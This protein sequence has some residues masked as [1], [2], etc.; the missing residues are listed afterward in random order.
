MDW[1]IMPKVKK[2]SDEKRQRQDKDRKREERAAQ[3]TG[4]LLTA[5]PSGESHVSIGTAMSE[6]NRAK[7]SSDRTSGMSNSGELMSRDSSVVNS[8]HGNTSSA[9]EIVDKYLES[10]KDLARRFKKKYP[11]PK[12]DTND[13]VKKAANE[14]YDRT[15]DQVK[16]KR[17]QYNT[18]W[19]RRARTQS[20]FR[21]YEKQHNR[22]SKKMAR[23]DQAFRDDERERDSKCRRMARKDAAYR[24]SER[25]S[26]RNRMHV[27]RKDLAYRDNECESQRN[28][29]QMARKDPGYRVSERE[30]NRNS[31]QVARTN[32]A[33]RDNERESN[34]KSMQVARKEKSKQLSL[35]DLIKNFHQ[36]VAKGP[37]H[38]CCVCEQLWY[39]H[40][41]TILKSKSLPDCH[42]VDMCVSDLQ[43]SEGNKL[44][45]NTCL[46]HLKKKKIPPSATA[47]GMG[48]PEIPQHLKDLHQLEWR[49]VSP[50]IP[51]MK[52]F[53]APR[54]G[55][56]KIRGNVVNVPCDTVNTFQVLPHSGNEQQTIQVKIKRD[57][58]YTN[59]VMSQNV[60]PYKVREA[61]EYLVTHGKLFK[62]QGI[63]FDKT[64]AENDVL[65]NNIDVDV[66][67]NNID[68]NEGS[69]LQIDTNVGE[70]H[71]DRRAVFNDIPGEPQTGSSDWNDS[72]NLA[73]REGQMEFGKIIGVD[74]TQPGCSHWDDSLNNAVREGQMEFGA[75][76]ESATK[77]EDGNGIEGV[78]EF[79]VITGEGDE[80]EI[81]LEPQNDPNKK[82]QEST[83]SISDREKQDHMA[84][85]DDE[86]WSEN[87]DDQENNSGVFDTLLTSPDFL[88]DEE[89]ELQY[90]LAPGQGNT[91]ISVFKDKYSEELAY[92]NIYC[93]QSRQDNKLRKVPVY[94]S[95]ICKSEL[96]HQDRRAAQDPDNL[97][98][99]TK[100][101]Q[102][103]MMLDKVQIAMRKS[104]CKDLS[105]RAGSLK[106][107]VMVNN[108]VFKDIGYKFLNTVRGSPPY[109]QAVAKDLFAMIRQLGPATF[110]A[111][112]SAAETRW[113][114]LLKI[115]GKVVDR[116]DYS[117]EDVDN[118]TW[119][120]KC[121][122]IQSDPATCARHF[123]RQ[124]QLLFRF[125][126]EGVEPLGPLVD[127]FYRVEFQQRGSPHI[128]CLLWIKDSPK[129]DNDMQCVIEFIDKYISC[130]KPTV[131]SSEEMSEL[132]ANQMHRHSHTCRKGRKFQCR[133]GFPKPPMPSTVIL[134]EL[135]AD[136]DVNAKLAHGKAYKVIEEEL[137]A[138]GTGEA[139]DFGEFLARLKLTLD[140]YILAI[141][142]S[143]KST[144][145]FLKRTPSEI[146]VNA[147][148]PALIRAWR[149]NMDI[150]FVTN[151]Y[152]CAMYIASYVTKAQR[153]MSE[154]L[155]KAADEAKLNDGNNIRQQLRAVGN[156]F[157]NAVEISAQ[158]ACYI[159]LQLC[160][161]KSSR[162]VIFVNT[163]MPEE[164]VFLLKPQ[165][166]IEN[167]DDDDENVEARG[168]ITRYAE[169]PD[170]LK[171]ICL[172]DFACWYSESKTVSSVRSRKGIGSSA[173]GY[174]QENSPSVASEGQYDDDDDDDEVGDS[175][176]EKQTDMNEEYRKRSVPRILRTCRFNKEKEEEKHYRELLMLYT[177]WRDETVDLIGTATSYKSRYFE[178]KD[179]VDGVRCQYEPCGDE[180]D[181][182]VE[183]MARENDL[184][185][186]WD[187][188]APLTEDQD[189]IDEDLQMDND[190]AEPYDIG[191]DLGLPAQV[192]ADNIQTITVIPDEE[193]RRQM[194]TLNRKQSEFVMDVLHHA[195]TSDEPICRFLSGGAGVGKTHVTTLLY[196]SLY[197]YLNK[198]PGVDP[199]K[200]CILLMAPTG[201]A[202]YLIRGNTLHSALKI[203]VNQ[204][205]QHKSLD[206]DSLNTLRTQ[207]MGVKYIFIDE[208][209]MV[210]SGMLTF[211]HKRL[212]EIMGSARD[213][214]GISVIFV[215]D[216]FQLKPVCDSFIF[217]NNCAGY[218]PLA[219]NLWQQNAKMFELTTV[220]RQE[221]GGQF[222]QLLNRMREGNLS[223]SDNDLLATRLIK[224]DSE[225]YDQ[226]KGSLHLYLQNERVDCHNLQTYLKAQT[227]KYD[228]KAIDC[229]VESVSA[230]VRRALLGRIPTDPRKTMQL[231]H[232]L[233]IALGLKYE[234]VLNINTADGLTN[235]AS[236][237]VKCVQVPVDK[238]ARGVIWVQF[239]DDDIGRNT[240]ALSRNR[241][242]P[243]IDPSWTPVVPEMRKFM[244][245]RNNEVAR[246]QFPLRAASAKTVHRSQ[247][248]T[249]SEVVVDF[250]GRTQTGIHYVA[251]SRVREF[252]KLYLLNYDPRKV[253][254]SEEVKLEMGRLRQ[255]S[256]PS[257]L[258]NL[259][260]VNAPLKIAYIN[261]QS[262]HRHKIDVEHDFNLSNADVLF[263]SETRFQES[264]AKY[265]TEMLGMS[266]F[267]NDAEK[268]SNQRPPY[269]IAV[270]YKSQL[271]E[272]APV[273]ANMS[274][275]EILVCTIKRKSCSRI[276][277]MAVYKPPAVP[278][279]CL[280][281]SLY[282][283]VRK[284]CERDCQ[285]IIMGDF[286]IDIYGSTSDYEQLEQFM[287]DMGLQQH[288]NEMT[289]DMRTAIDHIY[290]NLENITCG[291]SET[292][293]SYHKSVWIAMHEWPTKE[294]CITY[295][296][297]VMDWKAFERA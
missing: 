195:K 175:E 133:F 259:Y 81:E 208:V 89:R 121:R 77:S 153:G 35:D 80:I 291:V 83:G 256:C 97:F 159:L 147:Y 214:G 70:P 149:A 193:Y 213:F 64:W 138:M 24:D 194:R 241:Y 181:E 190:A 288:V 42:A 12:G 248:D 53:A 207:M 88:E 200:P 82:R 139:I 222:A 231:Q 157:L 10:Q 104:K 226:V 17:R 155:R 72:L 297:R 186:A 36:E 199:D 284:N 255:Q 107:P 261:A 1:E 271:M 100:K 244:V 102:M 20:E 48:F 26:N 108:I 292:Y 263:C 286:N 96:R 165:S 37:V 294:Q 249:V 126:K 174:L 44:I 238:R 14:M 135:P 56:K 120:E 279:Q 290:S 109:F 220:M 212:Q 15:S 74:E 203:P 18:E 229:V 273:V 178:I 98:F 3:S 132:V 141:R 163:N 156:K 50:R 75:A 46:S 158:E 172:A 67:S 209:S 31:M 198:R 274:A 117:D 205:L 150:Q 124:V 230:D 21:E 19:K 265:M 92:P 143:L 91:P 90:V 215:G 188:V 177:S 236:C 65:S 16:D 146:R 233:H 52:V 160:M 71:I 237:T 283:A 130:A 58:R 4:P 57:L 210:G 216:L 184:Q 145:I 122:L 144:T 268:K 211:V 140:E 254:A 235:G 30:S 296:E 68:V 23:E 78:I 258:R 246:T 6:G 94:Y 38:K 275:V 106:D 282:S 28:K 39:R 103:K 206:T 280:L 224:A 101:L 266:S 180:L 293:F 201:K 113:K 219:T 61:A 63:S 136:M 217:K 247:G 272:Q 218:A 5:R 114:H 202:A 169:R 29:M 128:H 252:D 191:Q 245:G 192:M 41:V 276:T 197:R 137:K 154:L 162:Q 262:L 49:L 243:G 260:H 105:L 257:T 125:L 168:L 33:Y 176:K 123:D 51:F 73:V 131:E 221:N 118:L 240:R 196:Q 79:R 32:P 289:T 277:V 167:M 43:Q 281:N 95:E 86:Q 76:A 66:L 9:Q 119:V 278:L 47:N 148:N 183:N 187:E 115:L 40:S 127:Y 173:D 59:H 287:S 267:R 129:I 189:A 234:I 93:G 270:Y 7:N 85:N 84:E 232:E 223:E 185:H 170:S 22:A 251:M 264:D 204:K 164:R 285:L 239:E 225:E 152:A 269:G 110:F 179:I 69:S 55:Q 112:F 99:K 54:G 227:T 2:K 161:R 228:I 142:S 45:C 171:N 182:A 34:R 116:V 13:S 8:A 11:D 242:K 134:E 60:R 151:V 166:I 111:S 250:T 253:K 62:D 295:N 87:E 25:E 27:A